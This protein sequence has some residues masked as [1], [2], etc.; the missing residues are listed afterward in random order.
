MRLSGSHA[1]ITG[2]S[3]GIGAH[4]AGEAARRGATVTLVARSADVLEELATEL[5][6]HALPA[7]LSDPAQ[8]RGLVEKAEAKAGRPVDVLVND[9]STEA[10]G[11][12]LEQEAD[13][14]AYALSLNL[15]APTELTRQALPGMV[16]RGRGHVLNLSSGYAVVNSPGL[17]PYC[18]TKA[19]LSHFTSGIAQELR[20][21]GVGTTLV[22]PGPVNTSMWA[23]LQATLAAPAL[24]RLL[25][26]QLTALVEPGDVARAALDSVE[27]GG[28]HVVL[29]RRMTPFMALAW[30]PRRAAELVCTGVPRR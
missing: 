9:A 13:E 14:L 20:G 1:L 28:G 26:L 19:G 18:A 4:L 25:R 8:V 15:H 27:A 30:A 3:R 5:G 12:M 6:G 17:T 22:E 23:R 16:A 10:S 2:A 7:D 21:T 11:S 24:H 29:P